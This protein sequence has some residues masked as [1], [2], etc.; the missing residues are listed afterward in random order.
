MFKFVG[1]VL[2]LE[3]MLWPVVGWPYAFVLALGTVVL[4]LLAAEHVLS[5]Y[6]ALTCAFHEL[7]RAQN[8][9]DVHDE[10]LHESV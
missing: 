7:A 1:A 10:D 4:F 8:A 6:V 5:Q 9:E 3:A 2:V